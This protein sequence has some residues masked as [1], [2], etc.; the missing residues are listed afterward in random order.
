MILANIKAN[1]EARGN[2][3]KQSGPNDKV[4]IICG[5]GPSLLDTLDDVRAQVADGGVVFA[6]NGAASFLANHGVLADYQVL[7]DARPKTASL[8]GPAKAHLFASRVDPE[9]FRL[10]PNARLF[11]HFDKDIDDALPPYDDDFTIIGGGVSSGIVALCLAHTMGHRTTDC[12]GFDSSHKGIESHAFHQPLNDDEGSL[13]VSWNGKEYLISLCMKMQAEKFPMTARVIEN[14]GG[15]V[16]VHGYGLLPDMWNTPPEKLSEREKY[17]RMW[18]VP[19]YRNLA[20]G[21]QEIGTFFEVMKPSGTVIDF[22]CGTG[23]ASLRISEAG[24]RVVM[25][26][27]ATNCRDS[28]AMHLP[29]LQLDLTESMSVRGDVGYCTDV[30]EH[31]PTDKVEDVVRNVMT[32]VPRSFF[33]I[34]TVPDIAGAAINQDLHL[35]VRPHAWWRA[36]FERLG[37]NIAWDKEYPGLSQFVATG[38]S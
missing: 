10:A 3:L 33:Q 19:S 6:L 28:E 15:N 34:S 25:V 17:E 9:C 38:A 22:G 2:W 37:F 8:V 30:L 32:C 12:Y 11:Q 23:R 16:R 24:H 7:V 21:E 14:A 13:W 20:P 26:D 27:F 5:S 4:A 36:T 1:S 18:S 35:T 29:F 31:I